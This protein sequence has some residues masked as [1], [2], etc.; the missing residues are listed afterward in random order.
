MTSN[1]PLTEGE[2]RDVTALLLHI[3]RCSKRPGGCRHDLAKHPGLE[4]LKR[5]M[6]SGRIGFGYLGPE[7]GAPDGGGSTSGGG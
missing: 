2:A 1:R 4:P 5:A 7:E 6:A 3:D